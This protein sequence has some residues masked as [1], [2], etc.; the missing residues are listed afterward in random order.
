[1][2]KGRIQILKI[3]V[4]KKV[5]LKLKDILKLEKVTLK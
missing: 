1:M 4:E 3:H 5:T 2:K